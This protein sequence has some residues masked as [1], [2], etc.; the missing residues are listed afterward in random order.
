[1]RTFKLIKWVGRNF[2]E[3]DSEVLYENATESEI[4]EIAKTHNLSFTTI[5]KTTIKSF[6]RMNTSDVSDTAIS[7][8]L[9]YISGEY[10]TLYPEYD[11][12]D[13]DSSDE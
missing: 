10:E 12:D 1:M 8:E 9:V 3:E 4:N 11:D 6:A 13:D 2:K 7:H 5:G